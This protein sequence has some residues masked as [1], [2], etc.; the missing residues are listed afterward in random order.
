MGIGKV[1]SI[2]ARQHSCNLNEKN[3][4][5]KL[6]F[7]RPEKF[8]SKKALDRRTFKNGRGPQFGIFD[9]MSFNKPAQ[10]PS[11]EIVRIPSDESDTLVSVGSKLEF[12]DESV[13][14]TTQTTRQPQVFMRPGEVIDDPPPV[15]L[16]DNLIDLPTPKPWVHHHGTH[17]PKRIKTPAPNPPVGPKLPF[18]A[19]QVSH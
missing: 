13:M 14:S 3:G 15:F 7:C 2:G 11:E 4:A 1:S 19:S 17:T 8:K 16:V 10:P 18:Q 6:S 12:K 9:P 5:S